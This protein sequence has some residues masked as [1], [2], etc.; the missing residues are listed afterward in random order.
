M[1]QIDQGDRSLDTAEGRFDYGC[2]GAGESDHGAIVI[3]VQFAVQD[4][5]AAHGADGFDDGVYFGGV[6]A[7]GKVR[8]TLYNC[9]GH[10]VWMVMYT[11]FVPK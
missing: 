6:A 10:G 2:G 8:D 9:L 5:D 11:L 1:A 4:G 3:G 7:F